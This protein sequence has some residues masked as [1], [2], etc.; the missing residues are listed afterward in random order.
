MG[1]K[2]TH[3]SA[4]TLEKGRLLIFSPGTFHSQVCPGCFRTPWKSH[5][6]YTTATYG[7]I[8]SV[9]LKTTSSIGSER[10]PMWARSTGMRIS[11][12]LLVVLRIAFHRFAR[13]GTHRSSDPVKLNSIGP[14]SLAASFHPTIG[15]QPEAASPSS[16]RSLCRKIYCKRHLIIGPG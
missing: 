12:L 13:R 10:R 1:H 5:A 4:T 15:R 8:C 11:T 16:K 2:A 7:S 14:R 6:N 3:R 9:S